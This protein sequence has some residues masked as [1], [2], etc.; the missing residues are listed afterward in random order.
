MAGSG[1]LRET[2]ARRWFV[3]LIDGLAHCH[4]QGVFHRQACST[5][6]Q[7]VPHLPQSASWSEGALPVLVRLYLEMKV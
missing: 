7:N 6:L 5:N 4:A 2:E 1:P 3:Q